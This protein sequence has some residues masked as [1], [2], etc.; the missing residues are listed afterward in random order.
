MDATE[1]DLLAIIERLK[2]SALRIK[3]ERDELL[4]ALKEI[5]A[6]TGKTIL[7]SAYDLQCAEQTIYTT[8]VNRGFEECASI[9][10]AAIEHAEAP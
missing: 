1:T 5:A 10:R 7:S 6:Q 3:K 2:R 8:G 4:T 9:A